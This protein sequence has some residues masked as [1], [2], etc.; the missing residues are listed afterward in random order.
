[1]SENSQ[2][3]LKI[4]SAVVA[5]PGSNLAGADPF[6]RLLVTAIHANGNV[7][8][9]TEGGGSTWKNVSPASLTSV[10]G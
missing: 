1:M 5:H 8:V 4:G 3:A 7:D 10:S 2:T 6:T 9:A